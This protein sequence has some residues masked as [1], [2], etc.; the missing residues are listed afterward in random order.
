MN[1]EIIQPS[2]KIINPS[3]EVISTFPSIIENIGRTCYKSKPKE[4]FSSGQFCR[5]LIKRGHESVLEHVSVS[6]RIV[7]DRSTSHQL[8][9]HRIA[10]YSQ[11]S[12]RYCT[13]GENGKKGPLQFIIPPSIQ[14]NSAE[15][16][17][18]LEA[19]DEISRTY[20]MLLQMG[21]PAEDARSVLPNATKT[22]IVATYNIREWRHVF[23]MRC[24][25][26]AQWQIRDL[27]KQILYEFY[28]IIPDLVF[29]RYDQLSL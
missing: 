27:M 8:V 9:R 10:A 12:Q 2:I 11:E 24:D 25:H 13:Y 5:M 28:S 7:C 23:N 4:G 21:V 1:F 29:D 14:D 15:E 3:I 16:E 26:H 6:V 19:M 17:V 22:E 18:W 20:D